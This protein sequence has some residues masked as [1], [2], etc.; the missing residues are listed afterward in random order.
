MHEI[1][2][3][4]NL[5]V[6]FDL[7]RGRSHIVNGLDLTLKEGHLIGLVGESGSGKSVAASAIL[8]YV[9]KPG[10]IE[11]GKVIFDQTV[12]LHELGEEELVRYRGKEIGLIA[13]NAR[14]HLNPLMTVGE[15]IANV[16]M[17]HNPC[18]KK[19]AMERAVEMLKAVGL[20]D[21]E[22][23]ARAYPHEL[24]GGMAQRCMIAM[25]LI[26]MPRVLIADDA[27]NGLDVTVQA[28]I[29]DLILQLLGQRNMSGIFITH[30][31][32]VVAQCC[33]EI[34][35]MYCGQIVEFASVEQ[36]FEHPVH[37][38]T[39]HLLNALPEYR[40]ASVQT[41]SGEALIDTM[42]LPEGC[43]YHPRCPWADK[44]CT[45]EDPGSVE[46]EPGHL[47]KCCRTG[48]TDGKEAS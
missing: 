48:Q 33:T 8:G 29:M 12:A 13:A 26:N 47:V 36:L 18:K 7:A 4:E 30:D 5:R 25:A 1:L 45:G 41:A 9:R 39:R 16:Y 11:A 17:A 35:I 32:G 24:S 34:A 31:L 43:L 28:Q 3:V 37:P 19:E 23:R 46:V 20:T 10:T 27:T 44:M 40:D 21:P 42:N 22:Q 2:K 38:Y 15:Q 6:G 14:N